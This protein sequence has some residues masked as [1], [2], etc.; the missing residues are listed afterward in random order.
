MKIDYTKPIFILYT[1]TNIER[2][3]EAFDRRGMQCL[4]I[5]TEESDDLKMLYHPLD[6][7]INMDILNEIYEQDVTEAKVFVNDLLYGIS[8]VK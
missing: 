3:V 4:I 8:E 6:N 5:R 1:N 2:L 7:T